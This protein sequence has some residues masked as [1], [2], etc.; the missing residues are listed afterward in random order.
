M[1]YCN[2]SVQDELS[3]DTID[4]YFGNTSALINKTQSRRASIE[5]GWVEVNSQRKLLSDDATTINLDKAGL[6]KFRIDVACYFTTGKFPAV[7][8]DCAYSSDDKYFS[9]E[10]L[11]PVDEEHGQ[12]MMINGT[13]AYKVSFFVGAADAEWFRLERM[14][15]RYLLQSVGF[16]RTTKERQLFRWL[17]LVAH[18]DHYL[19]NPL[20]LLLHRLLPV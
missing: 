5:D 9:P 16:A 14:R 17:P 12:E 13:M 2:Q 15:R 11:Q 10:R 20:L 6:Y 8:G 18:Y 7:S 3:S 1:G 19:T 4:F